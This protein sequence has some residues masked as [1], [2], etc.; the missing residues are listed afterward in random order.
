[1]N[2]DIDSNDRSNFTTL[3]LL[4]SICAHSAEKVAV[5]RTK[6]SKWII[7]NKRFMKEIK[8]IFYSSIV[9]AIDEDI[10]SSNFI[11]KP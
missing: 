5:N 11:L 10:S 7:N 3:S 1:M 6:T 4:K 8:I 2:R 9:L